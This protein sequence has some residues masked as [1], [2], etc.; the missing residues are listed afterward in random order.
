MQQIKQTDLPYVI[1]FELNG[2]SVFDSTSDLDAAKERISV[3]FSKHT[4]R[5]ERAQVHLSGKLVHQAT[6][7]GA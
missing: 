1:R 6:Q 2:R 3:R 5:G 7:G 4:G